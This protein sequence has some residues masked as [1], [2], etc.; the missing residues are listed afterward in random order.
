[1]IDRIAHHADVPTLEGTKCRL[2]VRGIDSIRPTT[3]QG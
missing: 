2:H 3:D 1:M